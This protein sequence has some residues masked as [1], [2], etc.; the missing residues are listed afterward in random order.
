[1]NKKSVIFALIVFLLL[2][3]IGYLLNN[4]QYLNSRLPSLSSTSSIQRPFLT[5]TSAYTSSQKFEDLIWKK[6]YSQNL[7]ISFE[8]PDNL[9][10]PTVFSAT[11]QEEKNLVRIAAGM[12]YIFSVGKLITDEDIEIYLKKE[13]DYLSESK[14]FKTTKTSFRNEI[15]YYVEN[16]QNGQVPYD[17]IYLPFNGYY[18]VISFSKLLVSQDVET[19]CQDL[20]NLKERIIKNECD[21][22]M[23]YQFKDYYE[24]FAQFDNLIINRILNSIEFKR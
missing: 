18:L 17:Q 9:Q 13:H 10:G 4:Q 22:S 24:H 11:L 8:Y 19:A 5:P 3:M 7:G 21:A 12:S 2:A 6:Y 20:N 16:K 23:V 1:M 15:A 14:F